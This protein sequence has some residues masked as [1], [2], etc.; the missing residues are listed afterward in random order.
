MRIVLLGF[1]LI[2]FIVSLSLSAQ[3]KEKEA[4]EVYES[5]KQAWDSADIKL[6]SSY[7]K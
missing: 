5:G 4:Q 6:T 2:A 1:I 7:V 3:E